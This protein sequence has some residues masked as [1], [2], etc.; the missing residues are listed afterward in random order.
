[1]KDN[2]T[3]D[4]RNLAPPKEPWND[5]FPANTNKQWS[6]MDSKWCE[7]DFVHPYYGHIDIDTNTQ[8]HRHLTE[9]QTQV[10]GMKGYWNKGY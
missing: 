7:M 8:R 9:T 6:P 3:V 4:G 2:C 1:M 10:Y 5:D